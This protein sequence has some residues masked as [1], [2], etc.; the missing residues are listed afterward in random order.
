MFDYIIVGAGSAGCVLANRLSEDSGTS[1]LILEAGG[2]DDLPAIHNP[3]ETPKLQQSVIDWAYVTEEEPHLHHRKL[4]WPRGKVL[5]GSDSINFMIYVRGNRYDYDRWQ[6]LGN[7]GWGYTDVLPYFK[8]MENWEHGGSDYRGV[9]GPLNITEPSPIDH[10][11]AAFLEAGR[12]YGWPRN[13][14]YNAAS[15]EGFGIRQSTIFQGRRQSTAVCYL[16]P[17]E[18]RPNLTVWTNALATRVLFEGTRAVG[19]AYLK[20][21][22]EQQERVNKEVVLAGGVINSPQLLLLSGVGPADQL[23]AL[24]IRVVA[25]VPGV[26]HNL[27]DHLAVDMCFTTKPSVPPFGNLGGGV[28]F[29]KTQPDLLAPDV[30]CIYR[31]TILAPQGT[32]KG[33]TLMAILVN[34]QSQ[35]HLELRSTDPT[36]PPAIF[37]NDL[38]SE[39][40]RRTLANGVRLARRVT[41]TPSLAR[42]TE[43]EII[44]CPHAQSETEIIECLRT[45]GRSIHHPSGT[46]K[47]GRDPMAVVDEQLRVRGVEGMRVV[48]AS[49]MPVIVRGNI[50][51]S[52]IMIAEKGADLITNH[53]SCVSPG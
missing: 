9:G 16:H 33:Y 42:I 26:G 17:V 5:G 19:I 25:D 38:A 1:V 28:A 23:R 39:E 7:Q 52:V 35:G 24:D 29:I 48:D 51:A 30:Q 2:M 22:G 44:P 8:K 32:S 13:T 14:D 4:Q 10:L 43:K 40:E 41:Q 31:P 46:C 3:A 21:G 47:M 18:S 12:E 53:A 34:I 49:I 11:T 50:N 37:A 45:D 36:Q 27:Q 20:D 6:E 15:Q